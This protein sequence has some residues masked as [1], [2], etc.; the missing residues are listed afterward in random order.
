VV[1]NFLNVALSAKSKVPTLI[2]LGGSLGAIAVCTWGA[3]R[4]GLNVPTVGFLYLVLVVLVS[5]HGGFAIATVA[6]VVAAGCLD[7]FFIPPVLTFNVDSPQYWISLGTFEFTA[8]VITRLAYVANLRAVEAIAVR[9]DTERL[10]QTSRRILLFDRSREPGSLLTSLIQDVFE[11]DAVVLFDAVTAKTYTVGNPA[12]AEEQVRGAY[13]RDRD[14]F[15]PTTGTWLCVLRLDARP[16]GGLA[17]HSTKMAP[18]VATALASLCATA[19]ERARSFEREY[20][21]EAARQSE[22]LRAAVLDALGHQFKTPVT[23]I[24]AAS[25][26]LLEAGGL[27]ETQAELLALIDEQAKTLNDL[28]SRLL[29]TA[30]LD[31]ASFEPRRQP[32]LLS[33]EVDAAIQALA[34]QH[35]G[36]FRI[37]AATNEIP[38]M[39]DHKLVV[40]AL[41]QLVDNA[42]KYSVPES[43]IDIWF[44]VSEAEASVTV[45]D[46]GLVIT[47][48]DRERI[49]ERFYR[50]SSTD[51]GPAG[52]GLGLSIVKRI[53]E[54]HHGRVWFESKP[55]GTEFSMALPAAPKQV[56]ALLA[57]SA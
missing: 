55:E 12:G 46:Q 3:Y 15:D 39:A 4:F 52:T 7:Y 25:S 1:N 38:V 6:S 33:K 20:R 53:V 49:F 35:R 8:L 51:H 10:Y 57:E 54:A 37:A 26:G 17:L 30:K 23:T 50:A 11:L 45:R 16:V 36:R 43:P 40:V 42:I 47:P 28:A 5:L 31:S 29:G 14:E 27:S 19:L 44:G 21:L 34:P 9:R 13:G 56:N 18:L 41:T 2:R 22:Q 32:L 24:W 48:E